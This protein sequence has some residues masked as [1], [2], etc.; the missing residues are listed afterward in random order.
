[1]KGLRA[2][3]VVSLFMLGSTQPAAAELIVNGNFE[4]GN[5]GFTSEYRYAPGGLIL[6]EGTY[7]VVTDPRLVHP[8]ASSYRDHTTGAGL[9]MMVNGSPNPN[10]LVW[11]QTVAVTPDTL[12]DFSLW[13]SSWHQNNPA[14]LEFLFNDVLI[15]TFAASSTT[16]VWQ[17]FASTWDSGGSTS[18]TI[19]IFDRNT[20]LSGNDFALDD[21]S[22]VAQPIPEPGTMMLLSLAG[23]GLVAGG[24]RRRQAWSVLPVARS[25][26]PV[27]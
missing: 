13:I 18:L 8:E 22:L 6:Q 16:G 23:L 19:S 20:A 2:A 7:D 17:P 11:S 24:W 10:L 26:Q 14:R 4:L 25:S 27:A 1:M 9:M 15:G 3:F 12:Y 21:I 5:V